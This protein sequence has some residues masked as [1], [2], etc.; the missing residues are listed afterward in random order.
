MSHKEVYAIARAEIDAWDRKRSLP[1]GLVM[2]ILF[3]FI[4]RL[5]TGKTF[6]QSF[7][8]PSKPDYEI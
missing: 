1:R 7:C 4:H 3:C 8:H 6:E 2:A 5:L